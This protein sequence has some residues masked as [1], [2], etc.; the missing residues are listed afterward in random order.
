[1]KSLR[2]FLFISV[3]FLLSSCGGGGSAPFA[4]TLPSNNSISIDEDN[5]HT[6]TFIASTNYRSQITYEIIN[7]TTN[8]ISELSSNG[9]Y[10]YQPNR[11]Y[12]GTDNFTIRITAARVDDNNVTTGETLVQTLPVNITIRPVNDPPEVQILDDLS[13]YTDLSLLFEDTLTVN[14]EIT[15]VDNEI[16]ELT[17]YGQLQSETVNAA[18]DIKQTTEND[19]LITN[20][21]L[22]FN[23]DTIQNAG[24]FKMSLCANDF[25]DYTCEGELEGYYISN[26]NLISVTYNCDDDG[27]N[28]DSSDQYLYHLIG[29]PSTDAR[30]NLS[31][32]HI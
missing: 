23:L 20:Q 30:T 25:E 29:N 17:F 22:I 7:S 27:N 9:S 24:L 1:M 26:K 4:L 14:V 28:C 18:L 5:G 8:G 12:F 15:D 13:D 19:V 21:S 16:S 3:C 31:L 2:L 10:S 6:S 11:D 32:I